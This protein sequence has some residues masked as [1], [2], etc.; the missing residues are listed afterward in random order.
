MNHRSVASAVLVLA[1]AACSGTATHSDRFDAGPQQDSG[2]VPAQLGDVS[3]LF[4]LP[5]S[6]NSGSVG[7]ISA[8]ASGNQGTLL[9][10]ALYESIGHISGSTL[11]PPLTTGGLGDAKYGDLYLVGLRIDPCFADLNPPLDGT[12]CLN[13]VRLIL[14]EVKLQNDGSLAAFDSG[15][16]LFYSLSR[17]DLKTFARGLIALR[18]ASNGDSTG[19]LQPHAIIAREGLHGPFASGLRELIL[20]FAGENNLTRITRLKSFEGPAWSFD[21]FDIGAGGA[22]APMIVPTLSQPLTEQSFELD[23]FQSSFTGQM[24]PT[25]TSGTDLSPLFL[26]P[27]LDAGTSQAAFDALVQ[28]ENP[29]RF[30]PNTIDC[31]SC[32]LATPTEQLNAVPLYRL[33]ESGNANAFVPDSR[34]VAPSH[35]TPSF[36]VRAG[37]NLHAFSYAGDTAAINQRVV[38]ESAAVAAYL[39][40]LP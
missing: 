16:H 26:G 39:N 28:V 32:H 34:F 4:P 19:A 22:L 30:S 33:S 11:T 37:F 35:L 31:A 24:H 27:P 5:A 14:Q 3:I 2:P 38:N 9:P 18:Q 29:G 10:A 23:L 15:L 21:G 7:L 20:L 40:Q 36:S 13:Q 12:G 25:T 17:N 1:L 8:S 6:G